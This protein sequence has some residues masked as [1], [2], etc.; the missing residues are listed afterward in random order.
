MNSPLRASMPQPV[1][2]NEAQLK[3]A[4]VTARQRAQATRD[5]IRHLYN[6]NDNL[7]DD[8][9]S[10]YS[11]RKQWIEEHGYRHECC[12]QNDD[13]DNH[14]RLHRRIR[15]NELYGRRFDV[16]Q[17]AND[18]ALFFMPVSLSSSSLW[19]GGGRG[20][21][22]GTFTVEDDPD[23]VERFQMAFAAAVAAIERNNL[24]VQNQQQHSHYPPSRFDSTSTTASPRTSHYVETPRGGDGDH[25]LYSP[26]AATTPKAGQNT[27]SSLLVWTPQ[28]R[29]Q[30]TLA[31][32]SVLKRQP[33]QTTSDCSNNDDDDHEDDNHDEVNS[34][35]R[36]FERF[37]LQNDD[38]LT[39]QEESCLVEVPQ[40][41]NWNNSSF[42]SP[43]VPQEDETST[44]W[45][46]LVDDG[47]S[48]IIISQE[49][50]MVELEQN[51][52]ESIIKK[53]NN[54]TSKKLYVNTMTAII[55][56][57]PGRVISF[58]S[59]PSPTTCPTIKQPQ[60]Q[61]E[62]RSISILSQPSS[63]QRSIINSIGGSVGCGLSVV[64][65]AHVPPLSNHD[66]HC[67]DHWERQMML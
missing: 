46:A 34:F 5:R 13:Q 38:S 14:E 31:A 2:T 7:L 55:A 39:S 10:E 36:Q 51:G 53:Q 19:R 15:M 22:R 35:V 29:E 33:E 9:Q 60:Q 63:P 11:E 27:N 49:E 12:S 3:W 47:M 45:T 54:S 4:L 6:P 57:L 17:R 64:R 30:V 23:R 42:E 61:H 24:V 16:T 26:N 37:M 20:E 58:E 67:S 52:N 40:P 32:K 62:Q 43:I 59:S 41:H 25:T 65:G 8:S 18:S 50:E 66:Y 28:L 21:G 44:C 1:T 48:T 56:D